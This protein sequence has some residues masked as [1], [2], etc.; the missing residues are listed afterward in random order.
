VAEVAG[1][2]YPTAVTRRA[3]LLGLSLLDREEAGAGLLIPGCRSIHTI[4]MRFDL[5][6][7]FLGEDGSVVA[8]RRGVPRRRVAFERAA[9]AVLET[10]T[11]G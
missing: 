10:P 1:R 9:R 3:R 4:G 8:T 5:D 2:A 11:R 7:A 6:L